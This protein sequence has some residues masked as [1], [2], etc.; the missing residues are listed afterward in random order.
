MDFSDDYA[1]LSL[2]VG[3]PYAYLGAPAVRCKKSYQDIRHMRDNNLHCNGGAWYAEDAFRALNQAVGRCLR[4]RTD[5]GA[6]IFVDHRAQ[7][8]SK[9]VSS[10]L[11]GLIDQSIESGE[12]LMTPLGDF[13]T[14]AGARFDGQRV[15]PIR[16]KF[17]KR[18]AQL[19]KDTR[20]KELEEDSSET[21]S[22]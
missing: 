7:T 2:V 18:Q 8:I 14:K 20:S 4:H 11:Q 12:E 6:I 22:V 5:Y 15:L 17:G 10:W 13:L 9:N 19:L 1:R 3:I 21:G 16:S